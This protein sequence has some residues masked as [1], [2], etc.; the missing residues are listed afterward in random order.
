MKGKAM[1]KLLVVVG[2]L[3]VLGVVGIL[4]YAATLP[5][6]F[7][8]SRS[9]SINASPEKIFPL[10]N[11]VKRFNEWN[12]FAKHD[13][14]MVINYSGPESG[15][16][17]GYWWDSKGRGGKGSSSITE[18]VSPLRVDIRLDMEKPMEGHPNIVFAL[19]LKG[20]ATEV[21][22]TMAGPYPYINRVFG[23]IFNMDKIIGG[24]FASGLS[25]LKALAER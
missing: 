15:K 12:P 22:W 18:T 16:G 5:D 20:A 3:I 24:T 23:T 4:A 21:S 9:T 25:D 19:Q 1:L 7:Q 14:S 10:I 11:D 6:E 8:V 17:A 2:V 13:P